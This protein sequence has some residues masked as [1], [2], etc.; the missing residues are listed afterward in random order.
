MSDGAADSYNNIIYRPHQCHQHRHV[1]RRVLF[2]CAAAA[3]EEEGVAE[4][5]NA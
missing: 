2:G 3:A 5:I 1:G 4:W